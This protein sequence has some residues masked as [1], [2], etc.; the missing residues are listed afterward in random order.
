MWQSGVWKFTPAHGWGKDDTVCSS[1]PFSFSPNPTDIPYFP[2]PTPTQVGHVTGFWPVELRAEKMG[3][4]SRYHSAKASL[5]P[6]PP[7]FFDAEDPDEESKQPEDGK[8]SLWK[9]ADWLN[10]LIKQL[11]TPHSDLY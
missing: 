11:L 6:P 7:A 2:A 8:A 10:K 1:E 4:T 9:E 3:V 5:L